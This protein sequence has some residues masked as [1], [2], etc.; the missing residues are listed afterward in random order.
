MQ[1]RGQYQDQGA[2]N[3]FSAK[4][5]V[6][7][8]PSFIGVLEDVKSN[9]Y[10]IQP[11]FN[12]KDCA[13][14]NT[15][16][17]FERI[18]LKFV[19]SSGEE[20]S[21]PKRMEPSAEV[22]YLI[23][24]FIRVHY[25]VNMLQFILDRFPD[26]KLTEKK[27]LQ[28]ELSPLRCRV[29]DRLTE[30]FQ[31]I[32]LKENRQFDQVIEVLRVFSD[33]LVSLREQFNPYAQWEHV[34]PEHYMLDQFPENFFDFC[35]ESYTHF[36]DVNEA[37]GAFIITKLDYIAHRIFLSQTLDI[38]TDFYEKIIKELIVFFACCSKAV[39]DYYFHG[40]VLDNV[41]FEQ[42]K[43]LYS[44]LMGKEY[45]SRDC[46]FFLHGKVD[47]VLKSFRQLLF[48][49][50]GACDRP[51]RPGDLSS[52]K[53]G[54]QEKGTARVLRVK[55]QGTFYGELIFLLDRLNLLNDI[56]SCSP[57]TIP[58]KDIG[59]ADLYRAL[60]LENVRATGMIALHF[61]FESLDIQPTVRVEETADK[62]SIKVPCLA[63]HSFFKWVIMEK[64]SLVTLMQEPTLEHFKR[65]EES[66]VR[67]LN[68]R[69]I[70]S[71][72]YLQMAEIVDFYFTINKPH[73]AL[74]IIILNQCID[75]LKKGGSKCEQYELFL[76]N[77]FD[78]SPGSSIKDYI[79]SLHNV[80]PV[81]AAVRYVQDILPKKNLS[82]RE[83]PCFFVNNKS[84]RS[85]PIPSLS[86]KDQEEVFDTLT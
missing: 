47:Q 2:H 79:S 6:F 24:Y 46:Y 18:A 10:A 50:V 74:R 3:D 84:H 9:V 54:N 13:I 83:Y 69:V 33:K 57:N 29:V 27:K 11:D 78:D 60:E 41:E 35:N 76:N 8:V 75:R 12:K 71:D 43:K 26:Y 81:V 55:L 86:K 80:K 23:N 30:A 25:N 15:C 67:Q 22:N 63:N 45:S 20:V 34:H 58:I 36:K 7:A 52:L 4:K 49:E 39:L 62:M 28:K 82:Q 14:R 1:A 51:R 40:T 73:D 68:M 77:M 32:W 65:V 61:L 72:C 16:E 21:L 48:E 56:L 85:Q 38:D 44:R 19:Q 31:T 70:S 64:S 42:F 66:V 59:L 17:E 5:G 37:D 53:Y